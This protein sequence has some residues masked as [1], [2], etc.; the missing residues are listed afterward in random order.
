[1]LCYA[2]CG[3]RIPEDGGFYLFYKK[4]FGGAFAFIAGWSAYMVTV[5]ASSAGIAIV[6]AS[7]LGEVIPWFA[8]HQKEGAV[9]AVIFCGVINMVKLNA[10]TWTQRILTFAKIGALVLLCVGVAFAALNGASIE[11]AS[12][13]AFLKKGSFIGAFTLLMWAYDGWNNTTM[14]SGEIKNP[15]KNLGR[16]VFWG[17][18]TVA[19]IYIMVQWAVMLILGPQAAAGSQ[20][21]FSDAVTAAFGSRGGLLVSILVVVSTLGAINGTVLTG[22]RLGY[23]MA[24]DG[25]FPQWLGELHSSFKTPHRSVIFLTIVSIAM[26]FSSNF[27][28]VVSYFSFSVWV[29]YAF[30]VVSLLIMRRQNVGQPDWVA[31]FG[32]LPIIV[33]MIASIVM[34]VGLI[35]NSPRESFV[36]TVLLLSGLPIYWIFERMKQSGVKIF[37][38]AREK[39]N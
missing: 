13:G 27:E 20:S 35:V 14:I 7:Y 11:R 16:S 15:G 31:P 38:P 19:L 22:S 37:N 25:V 2:E 36:G 26:I 5:P 24:V 21:V 12:T 30:T 10:S 4:T 32:N 39:M 28:Q 9:M 34:T 1:A 18:G 23:A 33:V 17:I 6:F 3:A 29:F 8:S